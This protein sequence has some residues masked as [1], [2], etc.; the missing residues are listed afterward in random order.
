MFAL[1]LIATPA[2]FM[3]IGGNV[4]INYHHYQHRIM[5][6][7]SQYFQGLLGRGAKG[8]WMDGTWNDPPIVLKDIAKN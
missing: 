5:K 4:L 2:N 8:T 6:Q 1:S 7:T 3:L